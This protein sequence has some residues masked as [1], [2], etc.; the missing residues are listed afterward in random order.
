MIFNKSLTFN[1]RKIQI[2]DKKF[3]DL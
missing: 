1:D 2:L 3:F